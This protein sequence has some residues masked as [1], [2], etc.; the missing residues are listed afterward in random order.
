VSGL[1][2][3]RFINLYRL[4]F[5]VKLVIIASIIILVAARRAIEIAKQPPPVFPSGAHAPVMRWLDR[6]DPFLSVTERRQQYAV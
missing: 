5:I 1:P 3:T 6:N 4:N 2:K